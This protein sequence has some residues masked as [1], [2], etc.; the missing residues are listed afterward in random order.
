MKAASPVIRRVRKLSPVWGIPLL[1]FVIAVWLGVRA[2][3]EKG[4]EIVIVFDSATG[5]EVNETEVRLKDVTVGIVT[6]V[7]LSDNLS[8]ANVFVTLDRHVSA[9]LGE[10]TRFWLVTP[11]IS[12]A[13]V[14]NLGTLISGVYIVM[15]PGNKSGTRTAFEG[16]AE[17]PPVQSDDKGTQY[18]LKAER[19]GSL[20]IGSPV[21]NRQVKVGE[22]INYHL[23]DDG[24]SVDIRVFIQSPHDQK[25]YTRSR[26][27]NV[28]GFNVSVGS[29]GIKTQIA[30]LASLIGGGMAFDNA[31]SY[32]V[33]KQAPSDHTFYLFDDRDSVLEGRFNLKYF[34]VL[35]FSHSV[36]GLKV[37]APVEFRGIKVGE[38]VDIEVDTVDN[39]GKN[40][41]VFIAMEPQRLDPELELTREPVDAF[42]RNMVQQGLRG[43][44][45]TDSLLTGNLYI[46]LYYAEDHSP[47]EFI[48]AENYAEIPTVD[49][50]L[51]NLTRQFTDVAE[52]I[53]AV[54][55][56]DIGKDLSNVLANINKIV[57]VWEEQNTA[58]RVHGA[59]AN[60]E[61]ATAELDD[62]VA[63]A[64]TTLAQ[65]T[66]TLKSIDHT[67]APDSQLHF[68]IIEMLDA[69]TEASDS[70][71]RFV[72][73]LYR[74]PSSLVF[75]LKK[76]EK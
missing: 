76:D 34:Y 23:A 13:G 70:F 11:R 43:E 22:V 66:V 31:G 4:K 32:E 18:I 15:D 19:L 65:L 67:V 16:L 74:Y 59:F 62:T 60:V 53:N 58:A 50:P 36:R 44:M 7:R 29:E 24:N 56:D 72:E 9:H 68:E 37:G 3:Q 30:S 63:E 55:I 12:V 38:V 26:F 52:K 75:G 73:E 39:I 6:K 69:V 17:P 64:K 25:V 33:S 21:Y 45:K 46:E 28:S 54:P 57:T 2:W 14:S 61:K 35:K 8:K 51:D 20:D 1:A 10:D 71:D 49:K 40:L 5:I 48:A 27:W 47:G 42:I 41:H